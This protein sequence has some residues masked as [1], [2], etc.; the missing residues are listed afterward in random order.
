MSRLG[1]AFE[2][3]TGVGVAFAVQNDWAKAHADTLVRFLRAA[4]KGANFLYD[5][6]NKSK[7]VDILVKYTKSPADDIAKSYDS[8]YVTDKIMSPDLGLTDKLLQPWLDLS[9]SSEKPGRYIDL[10]YWKQAL[11]R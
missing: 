2:A 6:S 11:G 7:A 9:G 8:F 5:P 4:A 10:S 1:N 3:F